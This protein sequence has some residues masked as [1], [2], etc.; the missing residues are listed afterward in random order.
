MRYGDNKKIEVKKTATASVEIKIF[1]T[2]ATTSVLIAQSE[3]IE[4]ENFTL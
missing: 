4:A 3:V 2:S 1:T